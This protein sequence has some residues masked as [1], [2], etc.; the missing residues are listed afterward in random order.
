[1]SCIQPMSHLYWKPRPPLSVD[2]VTIGHDVD[3]SANVATSGNSSPM[4]SLSCRRNP[5]ASRFSRP[6]Y[7][8]GIHSPAD[9]E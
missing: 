5:M 7:A 3:S 2:P 9:R 6:P 8:L 1:M 4:A